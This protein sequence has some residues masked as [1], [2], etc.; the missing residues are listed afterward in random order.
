MPKLIA[1]LTDMAIRKLK[2]PTGEGVPHF[3]AVGGVSGLLIQITPNGGKSWVL[4]TVIGGKRHSMGLGS[5]Q[6]VSL[7]LAREKA[8]EAKL[9]II[10]GRDPIGERKAAKKTL[11]ASA[12]KLTF[13]KTIDAW[14]KEHPKQFGSEK[15]RKI[16]LASVRDIADLQAMRI[17]QITEQDVWNALQPLIGR[18][19][20][21]ARR[22]RRR[23]AEILAWAAVEK[24]REGENPAATEWIIRKL[25]NVVG[26]LD[27]KPQPALQ[28]EEAP[29]WW[30]TVQKMEGTDFQL[31]KLIALTAVRSAEACG[32]RWEEFDLDKG[33]WVVPKER[34]KGG[35]EDNYVP[36]ST[37]A[38]ALIKALPRLHDELL[39]PTGKGTP[40]SPEYS[41][42]AMKLVHEADIEAGNAGFID[43]K[44]GEEAVPH[45]FR[46]TFRNWAG[47]QGFSRELAEL[48]LAHEFG[49]AVERAYRRDSYIEQRRPMMEAWANHFE[50]R[51]MADNILEMRRG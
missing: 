14:D 4:R 13:A 15:H 47:Q 11:T 17:D 42:G 27:A 21:T 39:F 40:K 34:V 2:H 8:R 49:S 31:V 28:I 29:R 36:L 48:A 3:V 7:A 22:V 30:S 41:R 18:A 16:W 35:K 38:I 26:K 1:P 50:G 32:A 33:L 20:D 24:Q 9:A 12:A 51:K 6:L 43:A 23:I 10:E 44:T 45:G 19:P 37:A 46:S 25:K 5:L